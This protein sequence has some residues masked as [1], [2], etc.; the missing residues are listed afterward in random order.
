MYRIIVLSSLMYTCFGFQSNR[1]KPVLRGSTPPF[2]TNDIFRLDRWTK[3]IQ[4]TFLREAELKHG[5]LGMI[6]CILIPYLEQSPD[7]PA[8]FQLNML[9]EKWQLA[10]F[11]MMF[12]GE[13]YTMIRGWENPLVKPFFL[14]EEYQPGD[15]GWSHRDNHDSEQGILM[16]KELN[17]GRL[18]MIGSLGM[19]VQEWITHDTLFHV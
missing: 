17:H 19:M 5:R 15:W 6:S 12:F 11:S 2:E 8:I 18:A 13:L 3:R 16:D 10:L 1:I 14:K 4:P 9:S 7:G